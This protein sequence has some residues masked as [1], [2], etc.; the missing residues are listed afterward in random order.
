MNT[1][2]KLSVALALVSTACSSGNWVDMPGLGA[3]DCK[4]LEKGKLSGSGVGA[5]IVLGKNGKDT[6]AFMARA[7]CSQSGKAWTGDTRCGDTG[8][9]VKCK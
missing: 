5:S 1:V 3:N 9:Q 7:T 6:V 2:L 4:D 8:L